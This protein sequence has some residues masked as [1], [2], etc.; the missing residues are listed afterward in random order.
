MTLPLS[1]DRSEFEDDSE[2]SSGDAGSDDDDEDDDNTM[3][4]GSGESTITMSTVSSRR[5]SFSDE[6]SIMMDSSRKIR[7]K[8]KSFLN[9]GV[10][11]AL[12][13]GP[14]TTL[15]GRWRRLVRLVANLLLRIFEQRGEV[16]RLL[17]FAVARDHEEHVERRVR[18]LQQEG[19][20]GEP[21]QPETPVERKLVKSVSRDSLGVP[22]SPVLSALR[23]D[24]KESQNSRVTY[25]EMSPLERTE[26]GQHFQEM[27][28]DGPS[29]APKAPGRTELLDSITQAY[30]DEE[31]RRRA[32][33]EKEFFSK[34]CGRKDSIRRLSSSFSKR[35][36]SL[37]KMTIRSLLDAVDTKVLEKAGRRKLALELWRRQPTVAGEI[38]HIYTWRASQN[39]FLDAFVPVAE[40]CAQTT[41]PFEVDEARMLPFEDRQ[42]NARHLSNLTMAFITP[43][44]GLTA[45]ATLSTGTLETGIR[46]LGFPVRNFLG[47]ALEAPFE[48]RLLSSPSSRRT[49]RLFQLL[50]SILEKYSLGE[51]FSV[52][53]PLNVMNDFLASLLP[54]TPAPFHFSGRML[55]QDLATLS[56]ISSK[57]DSASGSTSTLPT[58]ED[59]DS[60][61][62][63]HAICFDNILDLSNEMLK[64]V[65]AE[66]YEAHLLGEWPMAV[67]AESPPLPLPGQ[68]PATPGPTAEDLAAG[69]LRSLTNSMRYAGEPRLSQWEDPLPFLAPSRFLPPPQPLSADDLQDLSVF[70]SRYVEVKDRDSFLW[71]HRQCFVGSEAIDWFTLRAGPEWGIRTRAAALEAGQ[72]MI[73]LGLFRHVSD[74]KKPFADGSQLY[75]FAQEVAVLNK[76]AST[77][78]ESVPDPCA[79]SA[80]L[81]RSI[82]KLYTGETTRAAPG[83]ESKELAA[84]QR[85]V[86]A[87]SSVSVS[88]L[89][90]HEKRMCFWLNVYHTL[91]L[92]AFLGRGFPRSHAERLAFHRSHAYQ[93]GKHKFSLFEIEHCVLHNAAEL[94]ENG[95][96]PTLFPKF[97]DSDP[98]KDW[99]LKRP[100]VLLVFAMATCAVSAPP[101]R[102]FEPDTVRTALLEA[103]STHLASHLLLKT[104]EI[105]VPAPLQWCYQE[106]SPTLQ[107]IPEALLELM[108]PSQRALVTQALAVTHSVSFEEYDWTFHLSFENM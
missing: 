64:V 10:T 39:L 72:R 42:E 88:G 102:V 101:V 33:L 45:A 9:F 15:G 48:Y 81:L 11:A 55:Y 38:I 105:L 74:E 57:R 58:G 65:K 62:Q 94:P 107:D 46:G 40:E 12:A 52:S 34:G 73:G 23:R 54:D 90:S 3:V 75:M 78:G 20:D 8:S 80:T 86:S 26:F 79:F 21:E 70:L 6:N 99:G 16:S 53:D 7:L 100:E 83:R 47:H 22:R 43:L 37:R 51:F 17:R 66:Y 104:G 97:P 32:L 44:Q 63:L 92:H 93:V 77:W 28:A 95:H 71:T 2:D 27:L 4:S 59:E 76:R 31:T 82:I 103:A 56:T 69:A 41:L 19:V 85:S 5:D 1:G 25:G 30:K 49:T 24:S 50:S 96:Q 29:G 106:F 67:L 14:A 35:T 98:R 36:E 108:A 89:S 84:F 13:R 68:D 91:L 60:L 18:D 87:L 61:T